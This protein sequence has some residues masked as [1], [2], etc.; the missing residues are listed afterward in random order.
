[1]KKKTV[2]L[3]IIFLVI[4][5][6]AGVASYKYYNYFSA[7]YYVVTDNND[8]LIEKKNETDQKA[9]ETIKEYGIETVRPLTEEESTKLN[10]GEL[11]EEEAVNIVL[12]KTDANTE[13]KAEE[14]QKQENSVNNQVNNNEQQKLNEK[15]E[16]IAQLIGKIY[17]LKA[18][19][20][21]ELDGI[22]KWVH[23]EYKKLTAEEKKSTSAKVKI[24]RSAYSKALALQADCDAQ[25]E[26]I[27]SRLTVLLKETE[28]ST[29]LVDE[30][31]A[32]YENEKK[33]KISYYMD[34]I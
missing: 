20:T 11:T 15:K 17:V 31:R 8:K 34:K 25:M 22:E 24:G 27:L 5:I 14:T 19:F 10:S 30:I 6:V 29:A 9:M 26:E 4:L 21:N 13:S 16:E 1:M 2:I 3:L 12:G 7:L 23:G 32:A 33:V 18:K 28:Q